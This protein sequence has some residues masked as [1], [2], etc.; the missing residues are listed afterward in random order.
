[1]KKLSLLLVGVLLFAVSAFSQINSVV[2]GAA[3]ASAFAYGETAGAPALQVLTGSNNS[4][5][6]TVTVVNGTTS[7]TA[8]QVITP[9]SVNAPV[10]IGYSTS[11]E[12][13]TP[14][15][16]SCT[17]PTVYNTCSFTAA[18]TYAHNTG[19]QVRSGTYGLQEAINWV[20]ANGGDTVA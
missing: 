15:A 3:D 6:Y 11:F 19:D 20:Q 14:T 18:F 17:T 8:G 1:M 16:V 7:T 2:L 9:L 4:G 12:S 13:V 5:T 10:F